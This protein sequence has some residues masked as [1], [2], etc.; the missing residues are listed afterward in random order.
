MF[1]GKDWI[2]ICRQIEERGK[3]CYAL[4]FSPKEEWSKS[5]WIVSILQQGYFIEYIFVS[6]LQP[7][8]KF[9]HD[10]SHQ[11]IFQNS[12]CL[13]CRSIILFQIS[14]VQRKKIDLVH[15]LAP[16]AAKRFKTIQTHQDVREGT[17]IAARVG[18]CTKEFFITKPQGILKVVRRILTLGTI[19]KWR[20]EYNSLHSYLNHVQD[21]F[22]CWT[23]K[24]VQDLAS[25]IMVYVF[26]YVMKT[27]CSS[28]YSHV[29]KYIQLN[30]IIYQI[31]DSWENCTTISLFI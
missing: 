27:L 4:V 26:C 19:S 10:T 5:M 3:V 25:V 31:V 6:V 24:M 15:G 9:F 16:L 2:L 18:T 23:R 30:F 11:P 22:L 17:V 29:E 1:K 7:K 20:R 13:Q 21:N 8:W 12:R 28:F 14:E